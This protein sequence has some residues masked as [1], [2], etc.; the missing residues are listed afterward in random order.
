MY[1]LNKTLCK[2]FHFTEYTNGNK[3][4]LHDA[5]ENLFIQ[6]F[7]VYRLHFYLVW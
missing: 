3:R 1:A 5:A 2:G 6:K 7:S 4:V